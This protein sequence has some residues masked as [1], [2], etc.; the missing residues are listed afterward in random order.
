ME[1]CKAYA[2]QEIIGKI[3]YGQDIIDTVA[4]K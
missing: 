4:H 1:N 3:L 2:T